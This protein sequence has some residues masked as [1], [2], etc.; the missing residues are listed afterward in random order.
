KFDALSKKETHDSISGIVIRDHNGHVLVACT[1]RNSCISGPS[2][3]EALACFHGLEF[4]LGLRFMDVIVERGCAFIVNKLRS[5]G[6]NHSNISGFIQD[7]KSLIKGFH[8][9]NFS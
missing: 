4:S 5:N 6:T 8:S 1:K 7:A 9:C 3:V 2:A